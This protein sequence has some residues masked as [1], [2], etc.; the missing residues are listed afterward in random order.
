[1][2]Q[3]EKELGIGRKKFNMDPVKVGSAGAE[4]GGR[5]S[6]MLGPSTMSSCSPSTDT[7]THFTD[8]ETE[9]PPGSASYPAPRLLWLGAPPPHS[10]VAPGHEVGARRMRWGL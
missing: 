3:K 2:A 4:S 9:A 10:I 6:C 7:I 8:E 5:E 1:M